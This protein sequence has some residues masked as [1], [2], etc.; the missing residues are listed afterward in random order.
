MQR[1]HAFAA[2]MTA[3]RGLAVDGDQ[4]GPLRP[5]LPDPGGEAGREQARIDPVHQQRQPA[6]VRLII[7]RRPSV[8]T[9]IWRLRPTVFFPAS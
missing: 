6:V 4:I 3:A 9:T 5:D 1:G 2:V 7:R 8:S